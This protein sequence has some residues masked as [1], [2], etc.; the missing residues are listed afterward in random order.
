MK[1][2]ILNLSEDAYIECT[3]TSDNYL[4][5]NYKS[6]SQDIFLGKYEPYGVYTTFCE[7]KRFNENHMPT[8]DLGIAWNNYRATTRD[9]KE[10]IDFYLLGQEVNCWLYNDQN[11]NIIVEITPIYPDSK[12]K[13]KDFSKTKKYQNWIKEY[14]TIAKIMVDK[15]YINT[16][17]STIKNELS[18]IFES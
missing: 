9:F 12:Y 8:T 6:N 1:S 11:G 2:F 14:K 16:W 10:V 4:N 7:N 15:K 17:I 3:L 13:V 18:W 5:L